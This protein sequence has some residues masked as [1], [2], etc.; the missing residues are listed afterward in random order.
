MNPEDSYV[1]A[2]AVARHSAERASWLGLLS[3]AI[4]RKTE[5]L[6]NARADGLVAAQ[7]EVRALA[8]LR[9]HVLQDDIPERKTNAYL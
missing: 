5:A 1:E 9:E 4:A 8:E 7:A 3:A 2:L 6:V